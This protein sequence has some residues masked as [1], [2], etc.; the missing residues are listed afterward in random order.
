MGNRLTLAEQIQRAGR[1]NTGTQP[2]IL[3]S[4]SALSTT[5]LE[6]LSGITSTTAELNIL[7]DV[8]AT[9]SIALA[10]SATTDGMDI[11]IT[12]LD[13]AGVAI[14]A[15]QAFEWWISEAATGIGFTGDTYSGDVTMSVGTES[16]EIVSKK[17]Y[18]AL[19]AATGIAT[20]TA[21]DSANPVDQY[22]AVKHPV[23]GKV[24][25]SEASGTNWEG[26]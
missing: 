21:V 16:E 12:M 19:T 5:E 20:I 7:D 25:V 9:V 17:H 14:D 22:I 24:I 10:A 26:A 15:V 11:T 3:A 1:E 8:V 2:A 13:A 4:L 6:T 23:T 18:R